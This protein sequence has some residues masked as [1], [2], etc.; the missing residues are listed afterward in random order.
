MKAQ[1]KKTLK[2]CDHLCFC[3]PALFLC[4]SIRPSLDLSFDLR[5]V[6]ERAL[7]TKGSN[8]WIIASRKLQIVKTLMM[9]TVLLGLVSTV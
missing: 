4:A 1:E 7:H 9:M 5:V 2:N 3:I 6:V 8:P